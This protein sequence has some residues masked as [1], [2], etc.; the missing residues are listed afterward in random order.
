MLPRPVSRH[1]FPSSPVQVQP[2]LAR[3]VHGSAAH[4]LMPA[5]PLVLLACA[6]CGGDGD[7]DA[8]TRSTGKGCA[9]HG[10]GRSS[11]RHAHARARP[12]PGVSPPAPRARATIPSSPSRAA[13]AP[14]ETARSS[15]VPCVWCGGARARHR[16]RRERAHNHKRWRCAAFGRV[17]ARDYGGAPSR[18]ERIS[19][20]KLERCSAVRRADKGVVCLATANCLP[21]WIAAAF[22]SNVAVARGDRNSNHVVIPFFKKK[23]T[24]WLYTIRRVLAIMS[25]LR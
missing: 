24:M 11:S 21:L 7:G 8:A 15:R 13:A 3:T 9:R 16:P 5:C 23:K 17:R 14:V 20:C 25:R 1:P 12:W 6:C 22:G 19:I 4:G 10:G 18:Q 2:P